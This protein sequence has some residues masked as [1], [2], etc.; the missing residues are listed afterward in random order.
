MVTFRLVWDP[1]DPAGY[2]A[3][4]RFRVNRPLDEIESGEKLGFE[5]PAAAPMALIDTG[6]PFRIINTALAR[7]SNLMLTNPTFAIKTLGGG[8]ICEEYC[9]SLSF[10]GSGLPVIR[11]MRILASDLNRESRYSA[12]IGRDVLKRWDVRFDGPGRVV[13][14][15]A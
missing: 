10:P 14:I 9:A 11:E 1:F 8:C 7:S 3:C 15:T 12:L 13:T 5:Y 2:G 4:L 6:S